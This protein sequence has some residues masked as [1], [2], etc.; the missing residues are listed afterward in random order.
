MKGAKKKVD[1]IFKNFCNSLTDS[2]LQDITSRLYWRYQDD[3]YDVF[4]NLEQMTFDEDS[5]DFNVNKILSTSRTSEDFHRS[6]DL[7]SKCCV[8]EYE[9][10]GGK[11]EQLA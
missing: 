6:L 9:K 7:L 8:K 3:L 5:E 11:L 10:R 2:E 1:V 4:L